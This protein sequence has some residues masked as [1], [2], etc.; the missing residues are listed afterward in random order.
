MVVPYEILG[1]EDNWE[2]RYFRNDDPS[3][4]FWH[5]DKEDREVQILWGKVEVQIDNSLP[6]K[7]IPGESIFI[8]EGEYHRVISNE[9]FGLK[10]HKHKKEI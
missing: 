8:P 5:R 6:V 9:S 10:V 2:V 7:L 3:L 4:L 1:A